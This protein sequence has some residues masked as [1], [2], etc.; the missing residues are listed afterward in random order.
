MVLNRNLLEVRLIALHMGA[1]VELILFIDEIH[2]VQ[3]AGKRNLSWLPTIQLLDL[4]NIIY[5]ISLD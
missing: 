1:L 2:L 4:A 5:V 3:G